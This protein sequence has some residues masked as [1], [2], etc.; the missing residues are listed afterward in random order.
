MMMAWIKDIALEGE[1]N[2]WIYDMFYGLSQEGLIK[3]ECREKEKS[4][5]TV[6]CFIL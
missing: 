3:I 6:A 4:K 5:L 2:R 1:R